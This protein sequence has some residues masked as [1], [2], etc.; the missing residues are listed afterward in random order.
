MGYGDAVAAGYLYNLT[1]DHLAFDWNL[2]D[3]SGRAD[4][5]ADCIEQIEALALPWFDTFAD[6]DRLAERLRH[7]RMPNLQVGNAIEVLVWLDRRDVAVDHARLWLT[8]P[9]IAASCKRELR[10]LG[11]R[12]PTGDEHQGDYGEQIARALNAH[13]LRV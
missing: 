7:E 8:E 13:A 5:I 1:A 6:T 10:R 11:G 9:S 4:T 12:P 2:A 3:P